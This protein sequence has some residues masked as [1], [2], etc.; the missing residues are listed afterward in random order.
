M[1]AKNFFPAQITT[2]FSMMLFW[3]EIYFRQ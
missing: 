2:G 3:E 1:L